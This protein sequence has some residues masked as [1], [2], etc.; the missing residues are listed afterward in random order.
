MT[1]RDIFQNLKISIPLFVPF[2]SN[3]SLPSDKM[4][5]ENDHID[6]IIKNI[7]SFLFTIF[8]RQFSLSWLKI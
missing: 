6:H 7:F 5:K 8:L 1:N 3:P 2:L 4:L